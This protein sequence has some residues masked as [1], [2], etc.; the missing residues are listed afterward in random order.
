MFRSLKVLGLAVCLVAGLSLV[1]CS[2]LGMGGSKPFEELLEIEIDPWDDCGFPAID[3]IGNSMTPIA[4]LQRKK[5]QE[6]FDKV[7]SAGLEKMYHPEMTPEEEAMYYGKLKEIEITNAEY[8]SKSA[9]REKAAEKELDDAK[10]SILEL[11][12]GGKDAFPGS[13]MEK[14]SLLKNAKT[15]LSTLNFTIQCMDYSKTMSERI[16]RAK[17]YKGR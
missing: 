7:T 1:G 13:T 15:L 9:E 8:D 11:I 6:Y 5:A 3:S 12:E 2:M 14:I 10:K 4:E 17:N 16:N